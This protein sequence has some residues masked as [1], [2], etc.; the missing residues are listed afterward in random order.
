LYWSANRKNV[1]KKSRYAPF[2]GH[3]WGT[4]NFIVKIFCASKPTLKTEVAKMCAFL[5]HEK[6]DFS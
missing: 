3:F 5:G 2:G 1:K 6:C 4:E